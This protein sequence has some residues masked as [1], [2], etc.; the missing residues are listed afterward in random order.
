MSRH[1]FDAISFVLGALIMIT[2]IAAL[3]TWLDV[4]QLDD[5]WLLPGAVVAIGIGLLSS[6]IERRGVAGDG[7]RDGDV[8]PA[9]LESLER[10]PDRL[11]DL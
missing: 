6:A 8:T 11:V 3:G 1:P 5:G 10:D 7:G 4:R 2:G 9:A